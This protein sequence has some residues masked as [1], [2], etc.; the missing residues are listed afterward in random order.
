MNC[1]EDAYDNM[2]DEE[3]D[4]DDNEDYSI[5]NAN[6]NT[7]VDLS[8]LLENNFCDAFEKESSPKVLDNVIFLKPWLYYQ[9]FN[10]IEMQAKATALLTE[11]SRNNFKDDQGMLVITVIQLTYLMC[12][13]DAALKMISLISGINADD[14]SFIVKS[15]CGANSE[16]S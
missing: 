6:V 9:Q 16:V 15:M 2:S 8:D 14:M 4:F 12:S 1:S 13:S 7:V 5:S 3:A 11:I 10:A